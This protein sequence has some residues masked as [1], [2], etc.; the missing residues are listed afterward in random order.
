MYHYCC[1]H[2]RNFYCQAHI[3]THQALRMSIVKFS[4]CQFQKWKKREKIRFRRALGRQTGKHDVPCAGS[5]RSHDSSFSLSFL[6]ILLSLYRMK[7]WEKE[8]EDC[9]AFFVLQTGSIFSQN[10]GEH[11][12]GNR[13]PLRH[14]ETDQASEGNS[15]STI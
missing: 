8:R 13:L 10:A 7:H 4:R 3:Y 1:V 14:R 9:R 11:R 2:V 6:L 15:P 12:R 5:L